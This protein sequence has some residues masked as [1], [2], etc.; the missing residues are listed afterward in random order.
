[1]DDKL[2]KHFRRFGSMSA[3]EI[4]AIDGT[5]EMASYAKGTILIKEGQYSNQVF[6]VLEGI[7]RQFHNNDGSDK[8]T[9]F[10][11]SEQWVL[12]ANNLAPHLPS[13]CSLE[14]STDCVLVVGNSLKGEALYT[15]YPNLGYVS[16]KLMEATLI[17]QQQKIATF[18]SGDPSDKYRYL[19]HHKPELFQAVPLYQIASYIGVTPESLSRIRKRILR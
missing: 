1:M 14:C 19:L 17:E 9:E 11:T 8:T 3:E 2:L 13:A 16:R 18:L 6:F 12:S 5:L 7:I 15:R 10:F 4:A